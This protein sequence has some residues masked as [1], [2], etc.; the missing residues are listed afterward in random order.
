MGQKNSLEVTSL[1]FPSIPICYFN[2]FF[3]KLLSGRRACGV[4]GGEKRTKR[5]NFFEGDRFVFGFLDGFLCTLWVFSDLN[6]EGL[7]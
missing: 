6:E 7:K 1:S 3:L 5:R 4:S 2:D